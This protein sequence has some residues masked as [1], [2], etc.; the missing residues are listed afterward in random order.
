MPAKKQT[1]QRPAIDTINSGVELQRWYWRKDELVA[2]AR[3]KK[4]KTTSGKFTILD[5]L[6]HFLDTGET[7]WPGD[8]KTPPRSKFD[9]KI[10]PL[11]KDTVITDSY[12]NSQN[13]RRFFKDAVG[14]DFK[15]NIA[16]MDWMHANTGKTLD[17]A[18]NA[19]LELQARAKAPGYQTAIRDHNQFNQYT[20]DFLQANP[21]M[22]LADVRRIWALKKKRP[23][24]TGR[25]T[26]D[27]NDLN[28][29]DD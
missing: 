17:D 13:V 16:F 12:K 23:S 24:D 19:Y 21:D 7:D 20:R 26:Y 5:R 29:T 3:T 2:F 4:I 25:H 1:E 18:C 22:G 6:A 14:D 15:F 9:W 11:T 10:E 27:P 8:K 28:L